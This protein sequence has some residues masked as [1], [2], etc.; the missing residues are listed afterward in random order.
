MS[1]GYRFLSELQCHAYNSIYCGKT[2]IWV[3]L[4][5][6][7][8]LS[9]SK[10]R[11][12]TVCLQVWSRVCSVDTLMIYWSWMLYN[13]SV[14]RMTANEPCQTKTRTE[15]VVIVIYCKTG[16]F[17]NRKISR[18][19]CV[20]RFATGKFGKFL[21]R[22]A[23]YFSQEILA[24]RKF[25]R[26]SIANAKISCF[27]V[28]QMKNGWVGP[29]PVLFLFYT[30]FHKKLSRS[31]PSQLSKYR[32]Y[33]ER[34]MDGVPTAHPFWMKWHKAFRWVWRDMTHVFI[35]NDCFQIECVILVM[36]NKI[37]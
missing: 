34:R 29:R 24:C 15:A 14:W 18:S 19:R 22:R 20:G 3:F 7:L 32:C 11:K 10:I 8:L 12:I 26:I 17:H 2:W 9:T 28:Y 4:N 30:N 35:D 37:L 36:S 33:A 31:Q 27:T 21:V 5:G 6:L 13:S 25:S 23:F 1:S 16:K